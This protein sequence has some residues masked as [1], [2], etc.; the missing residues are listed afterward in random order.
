MIKEAISVT[1][2]HYWKTTDVPGYYL[3]E[4]GFISVNDRNNQMIKIWDWVPDEG[5]K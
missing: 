2:D 4:C 3:C 5:K 1:H